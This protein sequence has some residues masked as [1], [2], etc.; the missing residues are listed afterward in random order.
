[1]RK[2]IG[3]VITISMIICS[4]MVALADTTSSQYKTDENGNASFTGVQGNEKEVKG[5]YKLSGDNDKNEDGVPDTD[6]KKDTNGDTIDD[7]WGGDGQPDNF[8]DYTV[9]GDNN[10]DGAVDGD[11]ITAGKDLSESDDI[12]SKDAIAPEGAVFS[13][14]VSWGNMKF[15]YDLTDATWDGSSHSYV[16]GTNQWVGRHDAVDANDLNSEQ[17]KVTNNSNVA[18]RVRYK[19][20]S[21]L[22]NASGADV[23]L[24][25]TFVEPMMKLQHSVGRLPETQTA[26]LTITGDP[27][28]AALSDT[29]LGSVTIKIDY[30]IKP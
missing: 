10:G 22:K 12:D 29:P 20:Y 7:A 5:S 21:T 19:F 25:G 9:N 13:V 11:D 16:G 1:M 26:A 24:N 17:I 14:D 8:P 28:T 27:G 15:D 2:V 4:C 30:T 6:T 3:I 23:N 18:V